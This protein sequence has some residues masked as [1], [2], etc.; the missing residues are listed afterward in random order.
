M[1]TL[2]NSLSNSANIYSLQPKSEFP[3]G[4]A[5]FA[6]K[7]DA[8]IWLLRLEISGPNEAALHSYCRQVI[9]MVSDQG[10]FVFSAS[11]GLYSFCVFGFLW[12]LCYLRFQLPLVCNLLVLL[13]RI[14]GTEFKLYEAPKLALK[15]VEADWA[16]LLDT[17]TNVGPGSGSVEAMEDETD[18]LPLGSHQWLSHSQSQSQPTVRVKST[19]SQPPS[20]SL[21][22]LQI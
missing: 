11:L 12:F 2:G 9:S 13:R 8:L 21:S 20:H 7:L 6:N 4:A 19:H 1:F 3:S 10:A 17:S 16:R 18:I 15:E 5:G 14:A 22:S